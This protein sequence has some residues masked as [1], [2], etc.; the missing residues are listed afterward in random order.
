MYQFGTFLGS[1]AARLGC[2]GR[3]GER[4]SVGR[5]PPTPDHPSLSRRLPGGSRL[6]ILSLQYSEKSTIFRLGVQLLGRHLQ[7]D[8][9]LD[10]VPRLRQEAVD[11]ALADGGSARNQ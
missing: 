2:R 10:V 6:A 4:G 11:I 3:H 7:G 1:L 5:A 8:A 9:K